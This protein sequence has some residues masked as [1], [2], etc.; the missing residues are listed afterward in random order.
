[1]TSGD[2]ERGATR[3]KQLTGAVA[4][5]LRTV[6]DPC[7]LQT[8]T[9]LNIVDMGLVRSIA[10][11]EDGDVQLELTVTSPGCTLFPSFARAAAEK[12]EALPGVRSVDVSV[13]TSTLWTP[14]A[15]SAD[16]RRRIAERH[17]VGQA[18]AEFRPRQWRSRQGSAR[19]EIA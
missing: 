10:V 13:E 5:T 11:T 12:V 3:Q 6:Y 1:M 4:D 8:A 15:M 7:S 16:A 14:S 2:Q 18:A 17:R 19:D 9:P